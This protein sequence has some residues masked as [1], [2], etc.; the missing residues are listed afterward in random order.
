MGKW[1]AETFIDTIRS[2]RIMGKGRQMLPPMP[3]EALRNLTDEDLRAIFA[4]L[5]SIPKLKNRVPE[6]IAPGEGK[7]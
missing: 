6:P 4:Y 5:L 7:N 3:Y 1:T 2:G